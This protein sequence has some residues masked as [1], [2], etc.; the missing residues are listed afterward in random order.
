MANKKLGKASNIQYQPV[1][2]EEESSNDDWDYL[3]TTMV[4][5]KIVL[6]CLLMT[7]FVLLE[8]GA[9]FFVVSVFYVMFTNFRKTSKSPNELS[10][11]SVFNPNCEA[12]KGT[13][14]AQQFENEIK[15]GIGGLH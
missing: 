3:E 5:L 8:F 11:Y 1:N 13:L 15:F 14:T 10:A 6:W 9:V 2:D 4:V 7:L 12:I